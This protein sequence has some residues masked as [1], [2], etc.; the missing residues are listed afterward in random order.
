V[1]ALAF[2][3]I[4]GCSGGEE[5]TGTFAVPTTSRPSAAP[6]S[7]T[8]VAPG[9]LKLPAPARLFAGTRSAAGQL[10]HYCK[11]ATCTDQGARP[12]AFVP[13]PSGSLVLFTLGIEPVEAR[14]EITT[15]AG[16]RAG[17]VRLSAASLMVFDHGLGPGRWLVDLIVRWRASEARWRFGLTVS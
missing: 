3:L 5:P 8:T 6:K 10:T 14:A 12:P 4:A 7:A 1:A 13:A 11:D 17:S 9:K 15:T 2:A 16:Q